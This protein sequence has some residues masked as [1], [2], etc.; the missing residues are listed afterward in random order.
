MERLP[1]NIKRLIW[2]DQKTFKIKM[3]K[4]SNMHPMEI[5]EEIDRLQE[6]LRVVLGDDP[7][8]IEA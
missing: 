4:P 1:V 2:N 7:M 5:V 3:R 8:S 6:R